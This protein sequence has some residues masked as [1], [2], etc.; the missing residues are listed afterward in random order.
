MRN[1]IFNDNEVD[2]IDEYNTES[3]YRNHSS[4]AAVEVEDYLLFSALLGLILFEI[5]GTLKLNYMLELEWVF[6]I[7]PLE[8]FIIIMSYLLLKRTNNFFNEYVTDFYE[9][10]T[11]YVIKLITVKTVAG[12]VTV[13]ALA[14]IYPVLNTEADI[15]AYTCIVFGIIWIAI[16]LIYYQHIREYSKKLPI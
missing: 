5:L 8:V 11:L 6:C 1:S 7:I 14:E 16:V 9:Y 15:A 3:S 2:K 12:L 4:G 13:S 10:R